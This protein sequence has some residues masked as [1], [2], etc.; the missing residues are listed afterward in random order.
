M[1]PMWPRREVRKDWQ[2]A[3]DLAARYLRK[4]GYMLLH[5]NLRLD[6]FEVDI[7]AKQGDTIVFVEVRSRTYD[8]ISTPEETIRY[9]K[10]KHLRAA[11]RRYIA[12]H[13]EAG[14]YYR[15]DVIGV[16]MAPE[17]EARIHHIENAFTMAE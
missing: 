6:R 8:V 3:E 5:R 10:R 16:V 9:T 2:K 13:G 15:F 11:A 12:W 7:V 4:K 1:K 14:C 17:S